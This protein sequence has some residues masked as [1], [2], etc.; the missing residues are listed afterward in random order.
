MT[1]SKLLISCFLLFVSFSATYSFGQDI[2]VSKAVYNRNQLQYQQFLCEITLKNTGAAAVNKYNVTN[3]YFSKDAVLDDNDVFAGFVSFTNLNP[4]DS[5]TELLSG[6]ANQYGINADSAFKYIIVQADYRKEVAEE[7]E[8]NNI[9]TGPVSI[10]NARVD[11]TVDS[12]TMIPADTISQ[13]DL[14]KVGIKLKNLGDHYIHNMYYH[15]FLSF[16]NMLD[17]L[18]IPIGYPNWLGFNWQS[19]GSATKDIAI[20]HVS[21]SDYFLIVKIDTAGQEL[22][23][24]DVNRSNNVVALGKIHIKG[25]QSDS[26][27]NFNQDFGT[28]LWI[29][30]GYTWKWDNSG[31][32][33]I[34]N[35]DPY[36]GAGHAKS[37]PGYSSKLIFPKPS[38]IK[39]VWVRTDFAS[40]FEYLKVLGYDAFMN[41]IY[42]D[43]LDAQLFESSYQYKALNFN[44]VKYFEFEFDRVNEMFPSDLFYDVLDYRIILDT[45]PPSI[46]KPDD[47]LVCIGSELADYRKLAEVTDNYTTLKVEQ[48][49]LPGTLIN[50]PMDVKLI[51]YDGSYNTDSTSFHIDVCSNTTSSIVVTSC[52]SYLSPGGKLWT[53]TGIYTDTIPSASGCDSIIT[54]DLTISSHTTSVVNE[55][56][57]GSYTSPGGKVYITTGTYTD[58]IPNASG[59]DSIITINLIIDCSSLVSDNPVIPVSVYPNPAKDKVW[60]E[61]DA[62][63]EDLVIEIYNPSGRLWK[64]EMHSQVKLLSVDLNGQHGAYF[65]NI[66]NGSRKVGVFKIVKE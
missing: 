11:L 46:Q 36:E 58:T 62:Y 66:S 60:I 1:S 3:V 49:P 7:N 4:A 53:D 30:D 20:P 41:C 25:E 34:R 63:Y 8:D 13:G 29:E 17:E 18:D 43:S 50:G 12:Y 14:L 44:E 57:C 59:C 24:H 9:W 6:G 32:D 26:T 22:N 45:L 2:L 21:S 39:G 64:R 54:I 65:I 40:N 19:T 23:I 47:Q 51:V 35:Y 33:D 48:I 16:D 10:S 61:L 31:S 55:V 37:S 56:A 52:N 27:L 28:R 38:V 15:Y 42:K 5:V